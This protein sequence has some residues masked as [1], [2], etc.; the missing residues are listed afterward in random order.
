MDKGPKGNAGTSTVP[1]KNWF[2]QVCSKT[3]STAQQLNDPA[4]KKN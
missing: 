1:T 2:A 4:I 3:D